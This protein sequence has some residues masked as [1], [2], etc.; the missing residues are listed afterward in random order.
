MFLHRVAFRKLLS[1]LSIV[2]V[3]VSHPVVE[4]EILN[5]DIINDTCLLSISGFQSIIQ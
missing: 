2:I 3:N 1:S 4:F 5:A